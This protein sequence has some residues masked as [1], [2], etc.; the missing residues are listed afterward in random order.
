MRG[1]RPLVLICVFLAVACASEV[2]PRGQVEASSPYEVWELSDIAD[3]V[4]AAVLKRDF[5]ALNGMEQGF[6]KRRS[7]TPSG[8]WKLSWYYWAFEGPL[9]VEVQNGVCVN[10][11]APFVRDWEIATPDNP[12]PYI[13]EAKSLLDY[14][15][16]IR[17]DGYGGEVSPQAQR[18]LLQNVAAGRE[19][20]EAHRD[21]ASVDPHFYVE[22]IRTYTYEGGN[23]GALKSLLD[24]A[25]GREPY[26]YETYYAAVD[27]FLPRWRGS[28]ED[29]DWLG[30]FAIRQT[31]EGDGT[32]VYARIFWALDGNAD[33]DFAL[34]DWPTVKQGMRDVMR[35]YPNAWNAAHFARFS[36]FMH[37]KAAA[38]AFFDQV[39]Y[40][41]ELVWH[42]NVEQQS[43]RAFADRKQRGIVPHIGWRRSSVSRP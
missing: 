41:E 13:L 25:V 40:E 34:M 42:D 2:K 4:T 16:C 35:V 10:K 7:R 31:R 30:R 1:R 6:R 17:G 9:P 22:M 5:A 33:P 32:G 26:Y 38:A 3:Q 27:Y 15:H 8:A 21:V 23:K 36:C 18:E 14:G 20:L 28:P 29:L 24:E 43:C 37:D 39:P 11:L 19:V 12:A